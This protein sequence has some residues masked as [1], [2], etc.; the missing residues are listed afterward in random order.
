M[1]A[2]TQDPELREKTQ[3]K[4]G[5]SLF[6]QQRYPQAAKE[7]S[8]QAQA[9]ATGTLAVDAKFMLAE[10]SFKQEQYEAALPAYEQARQAVEFHQLGRI[11]AG[12]IVDLLA[13]CSVPP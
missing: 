7:F 5:W 13:W 6:Q 1:L 9:F 4:L 12:Q 10:C 3:Y 2:S 8:E 11:R